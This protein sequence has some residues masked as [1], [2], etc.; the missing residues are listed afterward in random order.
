VQWDEEGGAG[1]VDL[2]RQS[3]DEPGVR[4]SLETAAV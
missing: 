1:T 3:L 4:S 2:K